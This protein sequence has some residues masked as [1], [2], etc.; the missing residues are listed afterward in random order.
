RKVERLRL[1]LAQTRD[2]AARAGA[3]K[4][5]ATLLGVGDAVLIEKSP[6]GTLR[7]QTWRNNQSGFSAWVEHREE[8]PGELLVPLAPPRK[9]EPP[10]PPEVE[11][12]KPVVVEKPF[13]RKPWFYGSVTL[14]IVAAA[15]SIYVYAS[16]D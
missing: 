16:V 2:A 10:R 9:I 13:Y 6:D 15:I 1:E 11:P 4:K 5:L 8:A 3:V 7:V 12:L 14:G